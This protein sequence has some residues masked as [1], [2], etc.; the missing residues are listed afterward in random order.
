VTR[1][2][3]LTIEYDGTDF[4]GWQRQDNVFSVQECLEKAV[5]AFSG[6]T[7]AAHVAGRTD[8]GVHATGQVAHIDLEK[9]SDEKTVRDAIN[10]HMRPHPV[11]VVKAEAAAPD[12][13]ARFSAVHRVYCYR[14]LMSRTASPVIGGRF[15]W[16]VWQDLDVETMNEA[17]KH[18]LGAHDFSSFRAAECQAKSPLRTLDRL[19]FIEKKDPQYGRHLDMWVEARSFLHHQVRNIAG[20]LKMVGEGKFTPADVKRILEAKDRKEAGVMAP[21]SGLCLVRVDY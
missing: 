8:A 2:W 12:F 9:Q 19:E 13:H 18:L 20:T 1:R 15:V 5:H 11:A 6:E 7:V 10:F 16:H 3:K 17:A 4:A 14:I 21:A